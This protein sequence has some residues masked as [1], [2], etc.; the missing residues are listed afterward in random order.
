MIVLERES[1]FGYHTTGRSAALY[2]QTHGPAVIRALTRTSREF[3]LGPA[4][5][6]S[7][8]PLL[9]PRGCLFIGSAGQA[10]LAH[11]PGA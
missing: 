2:L 3:L 6:F 8:Y 11:S 9:K 5:G 1:Q 7:E 10:G 4:P